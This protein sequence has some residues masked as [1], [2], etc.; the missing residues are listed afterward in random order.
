MCGS[1]C[2]WVQIKSF[3]R[4]N[5]VDVCG[6]N[7]VRQVRLEA[8]RCASLLAKLSFKLSHFSCVI[9]YRTTSI[10]LERIS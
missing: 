3:R 6:V 9:I 7:E 1:E 5:G 8:N 10:C 4:L 2:F